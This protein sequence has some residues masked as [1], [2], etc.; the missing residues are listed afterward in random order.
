MQRLRRENEA[1]DRELERHQN[2]H[3]QMQLEFQRNIDDKK[4]IAVAEF[5]AESQR[6]TMNQS[7]QQTQPTFITSKLPKINFET[8]A[9]KLKSVSLQVSPREGTKTSLAL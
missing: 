9:S 1:F 5:M 7:Q 2:L 4:T 8:A 3:R 6:T